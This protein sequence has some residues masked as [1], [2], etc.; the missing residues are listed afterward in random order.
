MTPANRSFRICH[1]YA[2]SF[3]RRSGVT[4]ALSA[5]AGAQA[6]TGDQVTIIG[7]PA[8]GGHERETYP[9]EVEVRTIRHLGTGRMTWVPRSLEHQVRGQDLLVLHEGWTP[10]TA[11]AARAAQR[12][13]VPYVVV[14]HGVYEPQWVEL[15]RAARARRIAER[16]VLRDA[17]AVH[18]FFE[19]EAPPVRDLASAVPLVIAPTGYQLADVTWT[20]T[21]SDS[22]LWIGRYSVQHKGLDLLLR[23]LAL[24]PE[25]GRPKLV[26]RGVDEG[27]GKRAVDQTVDQLGLREYVQVGG[28]VFGQEKTELL[29]GCAGYVQP[30]R[31]ECH[32][33]G[34]LEALAHG[35]PTLVS[36]PMHIAPVLQRRG[37][38]IVVFPEPESIAGGLSALVGDASTTGQAGR[39]YV[40]ECLG[41]ARIMADYHRQL[42]ILLHHG[43]EV[44]VDKSRGPAASAD[45]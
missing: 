33:V 20:G 13:D 4:G 3:E 27:G 16:R 15:L 41:W 37:A 18:L 24:V 30:S 44:P 8:A 38:A 28:P 11:V 39:R 32:S 21:G 45:R 17:A 14:P 23:A 10:S 19:S 1:Y 43:P 26:M 7:A 5:W 31:W 25:P 29:L 9:N 12:A 35:V 36:A 2:R 6:A 40:E 34:L 22:L 42:G